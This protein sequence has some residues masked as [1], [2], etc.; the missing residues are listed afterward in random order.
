MTNDNLTQW[1][2][3]IARVTTNVGTQAWHY[4]GKV[5][6]IS[7]T[8]ITVNDSKEGKVSIPIGGAMIR[9]VE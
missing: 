2:G 8:H 1:I 9:E 4:Q 3:K 7:E 5:I 6:S